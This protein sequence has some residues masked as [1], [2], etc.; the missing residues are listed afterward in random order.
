MVF[1]GRFADQLIEGD[2]KNISLS[3]LADH[4]DVRRGGVAANIGF[5]L[6]QL[7]LK[8]V[9]VGSAG[10]DFAE[11]GD[12]LGAHG[13]DT[14]YVTISEDKHTARFVCTTD[15]DQN[16]IATF[17]AGAMNDAGDIDLGRVV[18][19]LDVEIVIVSPDAP[20]AMLRH[21]TFCREHGVRFAADPSQQMARLDGEEIRQLVD[22]AAYLFT[23]AY[24]S[25][26]LRKKTGWSIDD[27]LARVGTW[28]TT[29]G[30]S[31]VSILQSG[32]RTVEVGVVEATTVADPTGVGDAFRAGF[33]GGMSRGLDHEAAAQ[34]GSAIAAHVVETV[35]T[36]EYQLT[37]VTLIDRI[38][39]TYGDQS[40]AGIEAAL[41]WG[42]AGT[43]VG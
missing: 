21:T 25:E 23:N 29:K 27:V 30:A 17:Y 20:A 31:G 1:P 14:S 32:R 43:A 18:R 3:F 7:G 41:L 36:Q 42:M 10:T 34:L 6:G 19:A 16:Q 15:V 28:V 22:G 11:Y 12:W 26:L 4:L 9:L 33:I 24:E 37:R 13:V 5:G 2:L 40:A 39:A 35:G 8:P 38:R